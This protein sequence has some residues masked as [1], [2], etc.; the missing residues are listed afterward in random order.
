MSRINRT[1]K[2][3]AIFTHEG[4]KAA[5][6]DIRNQL[7]RSV[8]SCLLWED[9]HYESGVGIA[10][11]I[12]TLVAQNKPEDVASIAI[13]ARTDFKLRHVPLLL[14]R[15]LTLLPTH[16]SVVGDLLPAIIQ[17]PDEIGEFMALYWKD[18]PNAPIAAQVK[19]GLARAFNNFNEYALA[20]HDSGGIKLRNVMFLTHPKPLI[21]DASSDDHGIE[22][23]NKKTYK[24]GAV[25]RHPNHVFT[26]IADKTLK[27]PDTWEVALSGGAD[28]KATFERLINDGQLGGLALLRNLRGMTEAGVERNI[29]I[30]GLENMKTDRILP[31]RFIAA[32]VHAPQF[33]PQLEGAMFRCVKDAE[34]LSGQTLLL[35]DVSGSMKNP[36]NNKSDL[37][38]MD[39][40]AGLAILLREVCDDV[41][42]MTFSDHLVEVP[43]RRGFALRDAIRDSQR[44]ANTYLGTALESINHG[45][46]AQR[47]IVITDEQSAQAVKAPQTTGYILNVSCE[48]NGIGYGAWKHIDGWSEACVRYIAESEKV[49]KGE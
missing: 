28:K 23:I 41:R 21:E 6:T 37:R 44:H 8:M 40:A 29:I 5:R 39:A 36:I 1:V 46:G 45:A 43:A 42:V 12:K 19:K 34:R 18:Q 33:E 20:K 38:R 13:E 25:V 17:R 24:R 7:R 15:E 9:S 14:A 35:V 4:G 32:A 22:A 3:P 27:T 30:K 16:R 49:E 31:F 11:R 2:A 10:E 47:I 48:Q 26:R